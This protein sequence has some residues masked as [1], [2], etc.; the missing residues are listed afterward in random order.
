MC[1]DAADYVSFKLVCCGC[2]LCVCV[3]VPVH[4]RAFCGCGYH[5]CACI[6]VGGCKIQ[7]LLDHLQIIEHILSFLHNHTHITPNLLQI[8]SAIVKNLVCAS[9]GDV[10]GLVASCVCKKWN[11]II[12]EMHASARLKVS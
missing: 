3:F 2:V 5:A 4:T 7:I 6:C 1:E 8:H 9:R 10:M 12:A 11:R